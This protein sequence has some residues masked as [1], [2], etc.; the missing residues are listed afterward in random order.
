[1][2]QFKQHIK[3]NMKLKVTFIIIIQH[4]MLLSIKIL[5]AYQNVDPLKFVP[6]AQL[7]GEEGEF[8]YNIMIKSAAIRHMLR[9]YLWS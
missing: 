7:I 5:A 2:S 6:N 9:Y 8:K 4:F 3:E 1:M